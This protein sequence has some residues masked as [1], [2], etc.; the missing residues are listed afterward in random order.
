MTVLFLTLV[1]LENCIE[2]VNCEIRRIHPLHS[3]ESEMM[4]CLRSQYCMKICKH[5]MSG[6][7]MLE[8]PIINIQQIILGNNDTV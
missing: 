5:R 8:L 1:H 7:E 3:L 6:E 2:N 4:C